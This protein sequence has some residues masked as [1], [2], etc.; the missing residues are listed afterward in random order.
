MSELGLESQGAYVPV[1]SGD[2]S[3]HIGV[4]SSEHGCRVL[5]RALLGMEPDEVVSPEDVHDAV[6][7]IANMVAGGVKNKVVAL[8]IDAQLGLPIF[9]HGHIAQTSVSQTLVSAITLDGIT[10]SVTVVKTARG[11]SRA[12]S[13]P[14]HHNADAAQ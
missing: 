9:I 2:H 3:L 12:A 14:H 13:A 1:L 6:G 5:T 8:G 7:E 4:A 10:V 11:Q